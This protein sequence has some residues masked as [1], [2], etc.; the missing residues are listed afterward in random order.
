MATRGAR[1]FRMFVVGM[2]AIVV[3]LAMLHD[4]TRWHSGELRLFDVGIAGFGFFAI[5]LIGV[6]FWMVGRLGWAKALGLITAV[7]LVILTAS[8]VIRWSSEATT[9]FPTPFPSQTELGGTPDVIVILIHGTFSTDAE[10]MRPNSPFIKTVAQRFGNVRVMFQPFIW[11][12]I[13]GGRYNNTNFYRVTAAVHLAR[14]QKDLRQH[15]PA[16]KIFVIAHS[17]GGNVALYAQREFDSKGI[18][19][20]IVT[21]GTPFIVIEKRDVEN[22][23]LAKLVVGEIGFVT[24]F[25]L[26]CSVMLAISAVGLL[27]SLLLKFDFVISRAVGT[28]LIAT[29]GVCGYIVGN[30]ALVVDGTDYASDGSV[31]SRYKES[32]A[33]REAREK[34]EAMVT[35]VVFDK[36]RDEQTRLTVTLQAEIPMNLHLAIVRA[37]G[38]D[39]AVRGIEAFDGSAGLIAKLLSAEILN[40]TVSLLG[41]TLALIAFAIFLGTAVVVGWHEKWKEGRSSMQAILRSLG[42]GVISSAAFVLYTVTYGTLAAIVLSPLIILLRIPAAL[43]TMLVFGDTSIATELVVHENVDVA[44]PG[45][46][47]VTF[48]CKCPRIGTE[49]LRHSQYYVDD[50]TTKDVSDWLYGRYIAK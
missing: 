6:S 8:A 42:A 9:L 49:L 4:L 17:H 5:G 36:V 33:A 34:W 18:A 35:R 40:A 11:T 22:D 30:W 24:W 48:I 26:L 13:S 29:A 20:A 10:W 45:W 16:A 31:H 27:G 15:Y 47:G 28:L 50:S 1:L 43:P 37:K 3:T 38:D 7:T 23:D 12:G 14:L 21:L 41:V 46:A 2:Y 19:D 39:E 32:P 44:P 25:A